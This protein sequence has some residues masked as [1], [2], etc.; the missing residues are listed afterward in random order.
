MDH[1]DFERLIK[2]TI[3]LYTQADISF[4]KKDAATVR[5]LLVAIDKLKKLTS[6]YMKGQEE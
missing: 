3:D 4:A 1:H 2:I 6:T 5:T